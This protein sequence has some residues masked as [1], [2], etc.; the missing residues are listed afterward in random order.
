MS[1]CSIASARDTPSFAT[2]ASNGYRLITTR[3]MSQMPC[4]AIAV[5][6]L[7]S[8]R[9]ARIP[10]WTLGCSVFTRPCIISGKPVY[11]DT[12]RT[13]MPAVASAL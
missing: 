1:I 8:S 11:S 3:S 6:W 4:S 9:S 10:P 7:G 5:T 13:G 12:S 2:V